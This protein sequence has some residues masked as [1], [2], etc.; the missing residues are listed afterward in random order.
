MKLFKYIV[1]V[2]VMAPVSLL[3]GTFSDVNVNELGQY[4][5]PNNRPASPQEYVYMPDGLSYLTLSDDGKSISSHD[6]K[7]GNVI[8]T[9]LDVAKTRET[10]IERIKGFSI[11]PDGSKLLV[12][13]DSE[14]V[15]RHSFNADYHV[16][17][18]KRNILS[19][20]SSKFEMQQA[21]LFSPD[22]RMVAFVA[23]N[24]IYIK[25]LD[26]KTEVPVT[27]D[28][29]VNEIINGVPD[30]TYQEEFSTTSSMTWAPD[31][32]TLCYVKYDEKDVPTFSFPLYQG[33]C[34]PR[35]EYSLYPGQFTY[36]YPVAGMKNSSV[37]V[38]SYDVETRKTKTISLADNAIEYIPRISYAC[39]PER[40]VVTTLNRGQTRMEMYTVNPKST[41]AKSLYVEEASAWIA[42]EAYEKV[43][44]YPDY[45][46]IMSERSGYNHLYQYSYSGA[47]MRQI[48][49]GNYDVTD[50]YGCNARGTHFYQSTA[51]GAINRVVSG[52]DI[53]GKRTDLSALEGT[54]SASFSPTMENYVLSYSNAYTPP[55]YRMF[56]SRNKEL[57]VIEDNASYKARY[58]AVPAKE[59]FTMESDGVSLNGY[60]LKPADFNAS[61]KYPVIMS[62]YSGP[63]SQEVLNRW[64]MDWEYYFVQQGYIVMSVDGRGTGGRGCEF[65]NVV[66]KRLGHYETIDQIAAARYAASLPYVDKDRIGIYGWSYGGYET[67][68]AISHPD[69]PYSA[70][71]AIAPVTD[72][73]YYD[74]VYAERYMLTPQENEDG[75]NAGAPI[76]LT[77]NM[78]CRLLL[79][80][81]TA[82]DNVHFTNT[83]QYVSVLQ[84]QGKLCDMFI[85]PNMNHS[86]NGCNARAVVYAKMLDYFNCNLKR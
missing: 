5:Y 66:Y 81:G 72:W 86:I 36:K 48:T 71:V 49:S 12:Y 31:N 13:R 80:S 78:N 25:K 37:S 59:F 73:R 77:E 9:V 3:A 6:T 83:L 35:D 61:R 11:S 19:P 2:I 24:N 16:F 68:M 23:E 27:T 53:K 51:S 79:M 34:N 47:M 17:E 29:K 45:F 60:M 14:P 28:G 46:V 15:Y 50:Y 58:G 26:Y 75:Y 74:T 10:K 62:Q 33:T 76:K 57:R 63:G 85:F 18:I 65:R 7:T 64:K 55:Q 32:L 84:S 30:W 56:D 42:P 8:E 70:A 54:S 21:P 43:K 44:F 39:T 67:L 1:P 52:I 69:S 82:D 41:V 4:V 38:H 22:G 20:L 40:L